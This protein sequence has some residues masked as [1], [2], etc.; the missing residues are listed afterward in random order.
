MPKI[1]LDSQQMA[2][3][4]TGLNC[5]VRW[6][7]DA[8]AVYADAGE[9][10]SHPGRRIFQAQ[11]DGL[12]ELQKLLTSDPTGCAIVEVSRLPTPPGS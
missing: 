8:V 3:L 12:R 9:D 11:L 6:Y 2:T 10:P 4:A 1:T 5:A 7:A